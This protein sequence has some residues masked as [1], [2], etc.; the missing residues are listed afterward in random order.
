M[1]RKIEDCKAYTVDIALK[2]G[3]IEGH[4]HYQKFIIL[5]MG[6]TGS[7]M[8][9]SSLR[10]HSQVVVFGEIFNNNHKL[11][12]WEYP[13]YARYRTLESALSLRE[14]DPKSFLNTLV[15]QRFP[16]NIPAV[17][18]KLFYYHAQDENW[19]CIW[20]Y[21]KA[22]TNLKIIHIK[23]NNIL[24]TFRSLRIAFITGKWSKRS[25][26]ES[27]VPGPIELEY[28]RCLEAFEKTRKAEDK[29]DRFFEKHQKVTVIYEDLVKDYS[30]HTKHIQEFLGVKHKALHPSTKKQNI[31]P[32]SKAISNYREL[33]EQ[34]QDSPWAEFF[35]E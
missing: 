28:E 27:I 4:R 31:Q 25:G 22:M 15:F 2:A 8:L 10:S 1:L 6:R 17:G 20:P 14:S 32:L 3:L 13:G 29:Y 30:K 18:F 19:K 7:N 9:A 11:I 16:K 5:G 21:L 34:F 24:K 26:G 23:R 35:E 33:K 12:L